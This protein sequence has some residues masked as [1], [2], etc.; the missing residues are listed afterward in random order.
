MD[1][2]PTGNPIVYKIRLE[3]WSEIRSI[4]RSDR[5]SDEKSKRQFRSEFLFPIGNFFR[6][7]SYP[8]GIS[9][10]S[11]SGRPVRPV[12]YASLLCVSTQL[13]N[14]RWREECNLSKHC[15]ARALRPAISRRFYFFLRPT[16]H[17][18]IR[19]KWK[20]PLKPLATLTVLKGSSYKGGRSHRFF[21]AEK[22]CLFVFSPFIIKLLWLVNGS[23]I[24]ARST[25]LS[26]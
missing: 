8:V 3:I 1:K 12:P 11:G 25:A 19:Q 26:R 7:L 10:V 23:K 21:Q 22:T 20:S 2:N 4:I 6:I 14:E 16:I 9:G 13:G 5:I 24:T 17:K 18:F 15:T